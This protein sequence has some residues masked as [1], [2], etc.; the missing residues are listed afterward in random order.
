MV[1]TVGLACASALGVAHAGLDAHARLS[2]RLP[3]ALE[4]R[5]LA[6]TGRIVGLPRT[7]PDAVSFLLEVDHCRGLGRVASALCAVGPRR[8]SLSWRRFAGDG[9]ALPALR[10]GQRWRLPVR[11][12]RPYG[13]ANAHGFDFEAWALQRGIDATGHVQ[14]DRGA[15]R[16]AEPADASLGWR[17]RI[18]RLRQRLRM[19]IEASVGVKA[20][21]ATASTR[22]G[23]RAEWNSRGSRGEPADAAQSARSAQSD[24]L[25]RSDRSVEGHEADE[26][27]ASRSRLTRLPERRSSDTQVSDGI[28]ARSRMPVLTALTIGDQRGL[29]SSVRAWL[30]QTG[31]S[32]LL[33]I[34]GLHVG[35]VAGGVA[36]LASV[37]WRCAI[38]RGRPLALFVPAQLIAAP[39]AAIGAC[40]VVAL[41]GFG[42]PALRAGWM[43][44]VALVTWT[45]RRRT[46]ATVTLCWALLLVLAADPSAILS[47]GFWLSFCAVAAILLAT[48][49][50]PPGSDAASRAGGPPMGPRDVGGWRARWQS[51]RAATRVQMAVTL[52]LVPLTADWFSQVSLISPAANAL[53]IPWVSFLLLPVAM[54]GVLMPP[55]FDH[56]CYRAAAHLSDGLLYFL[57]ALTSVPLASVT[58]P[59]TG[60]VATALAFAAMVLPWM[61]WRRADRLRLPIAACCG[62]PIC[63]MAGAAAWGRVAEGE[64]RVTAYDVGQ[65]GGVLVETA[66]HRLLFD[67]GPPH[68]ESDIGERVIVP[69]L[70]A[71]AVAR[72]DMLMLSHVH[73]DH[74]GGALSVIRAVP[75]R[76]LSGSLPRT[77]AARL[78]MAAAGGANTFCVRGQR[79]TWDGVRFEVLWPPRPESGSGSGGANASSCVLRVDNGRHVALLSGDI[80]A[81]Q[82]ARLLAYHARGASRR[83]PRR[84]PAARAPAG[85]PT[86]AVRGAAVN[87]DAAAGPNRFEDSGRDTLPGLRADVAFAPHHG[88]RTSSTL[89]WVRALGASEVVCQVGYRNR[90]GHPHRTVTARYARHGARLHR[91]DRDGMIHF[92]TR[93]GEL[94][95]ERFREAQR[96]YWMPDW[97]A[98]REMSP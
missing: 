77:H 64:Y 81:A 67:T 26:A 42:V 31:T 29:P 33:A 74:T 5:T 69:H 46:R 41:S 61:R 92:E 12:Q 43:T 72:L 91:T 60:P 44:T 2:T 16:L 62:L 28:V 89:P 71:C 53:A 4:G 39:I 84:V 95:S 97:P 66:S 58:L 40:F 49:P 38:W 78:A 17:D 75:I 30:A 45:L 14:T 83:V 34:S 85:P 65:G 57:A 79:W 96:R 25:D 93:G 11:L 37:L 6:L 13:T 3:V 20:P 50:R 80:E 63:V 8:V 15:A 98:E 22:V 55:P 32:H 87:L 88:S 86:P 1:R 82:E 48:S 56:F 35:I 27:D 94:R 52:A 68:G 47:A 76:V 23:T 19:D 70:R 7:G 73:V 21:R 9:R 24:R 51:V 10:P 59:P 54:I 90:F 18:D 36:W